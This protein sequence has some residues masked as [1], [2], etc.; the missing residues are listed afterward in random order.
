VDQRKKDVAAIT[1]DWEQNP[2]W[3]DVKRGYSVEDAVRLRGVL[4][5]YG[6]AIK[7]LAG[8]GIFPG[9][10]LLKNFGVTRHERVVFYDYDEIQPMEEVV[11]RPIPPAASYEEEIADL[12]DPA[13]WAGKQ[14]LVRDGLQEDVFPYPE[15]VR[16]PRA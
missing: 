6:D 4:R 1:K 16:F 12:L 9:D 13:F 14:A 10:M 3:S 11:F 7:Q 5:E 2:R 15:E 8:A